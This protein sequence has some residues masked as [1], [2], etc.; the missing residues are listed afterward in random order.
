MLERSSTRLHESIY[1]EDPAI[2]ADLEEKDGGED[3]DPKFNDELVREQ[4]ANA[5]DAYKAKI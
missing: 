3:D 2:I 1:V 5:V 4:L